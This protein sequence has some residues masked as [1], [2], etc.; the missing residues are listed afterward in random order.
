LD[1]QHGAYY[2]KRV[3]TTST[4]PS[5]PVDGDLWWDDENGR[6]FIYYDDGT[7]VQWV[8]A[9][10]SSTNIQYDPLTTTYTMAGNLV[11]TGDINSASDIT[12][13]E[14][15]ITTQ[16]ALDK[17]LLLRGVNF[18]WKSSGKQSIGLIAQEVEQVLPELVATDASGIKSVQ[19]SNIVAILI[20]AIKEQNSKIA[21]LEEAMKDIVNGNN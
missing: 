19:Y 3:A 13:K 5:S 15:I 10:P 20:E 16:N 11:V 17:T 21:Y 18:D 14:N 6:L 2:Q 7:S 4:P 8:E 1:G 9:S 12:L